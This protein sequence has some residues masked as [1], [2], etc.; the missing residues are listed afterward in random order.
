MG[1]EL[2]AFAGVVSGESRWGV[3]AGLTPLAGLAYLDP[4]VLGAHHACA[5]CG[6]R[7]TRSH[8]SCA[9]RQIKNK[10]KR[11]PCRLGQTSRAGLGWVRRSCCAPIPHS[12]RA[13]IKNKVRG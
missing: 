6:L 8:A 9:K 3:D 11:A 4:T 13:A 7:A 5:G 12:A 2:P 10:P 1:V